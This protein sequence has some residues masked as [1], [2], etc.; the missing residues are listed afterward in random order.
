[1]AVFKVEDIKGYCFQ[2][3]MVCTDC[4]DREEINS[5]KVDEVITENEIQKGDDLYF[6]DRCKERI[7]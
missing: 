1:M 5:L 7:L 6:C 3:E 2:D 4:A